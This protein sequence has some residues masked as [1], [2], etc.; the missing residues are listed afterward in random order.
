MNLREKTRI[1]RINLIKE[2][3]NKCLKEGRNI[4][5]KEFV[6][7]VMATYKVSRRIAKEYV[8]TARYELR[9]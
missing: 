2:S 7:Y 5:F 3:L 6:T 9:I 8:D 4:D 1:E